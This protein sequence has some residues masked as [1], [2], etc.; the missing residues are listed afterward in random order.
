MS[1]HIVCC[2]CPTT[3]PALLAH[4]RITPDE[5]GDWKGLK[6]LYGSFQGGGIREGGLLYR[7][8]QERH[9][10]QP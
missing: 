3:T 2:L 6:F 9:L 5:I 7:F 8:P 10:G 4:I 1:S